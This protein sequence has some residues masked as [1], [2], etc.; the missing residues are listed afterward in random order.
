LGKITYFGS[1]K[2]IARAT[3]VINNGQKLTKMSEAKARLKIQTLIDEH[4]LKATVL[5]NGNTVWSKTRI[6]RS[7]RRIMKE[8]TLYN[9]IQEKPPFLSLYFYEFLHQECGSIAHYDIHG[10]MHKYPTLEE[11]KQFF[12]KN[13]FGQKVTDYIPGRFSDARAIIEEIETQLHPFLSY[14][15]TRQ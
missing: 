5:Y 14:L 13:E 6:L 9:P 2:D 10:W 3:A 4:K 7:L 1:E 11:L 8:K 12:D 15:K